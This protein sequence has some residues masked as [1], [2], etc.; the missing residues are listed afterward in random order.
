MS[1]NAPALTVRQRAVISLTSDSWEHAVTQA[2]SDA[3]RAGKPVKFESDQTGH[4]ALLFAIYEA[5]DH[6]RICEERRLETWLAQQSATIGRLVLCACDRSRPAVSL[7]KV[8]ELVIDQAGQLDSFSLR[9]YTVEDFSGQ[10]QGIL[11]RQMQQHSASL[12]F[13]D[14]PIDALANDDAIT[15]RPPIF[16]IGH[17]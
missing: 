12:A 6:A 3:Q 16:R 2:I 14:D 4:V 11:G 15:P 10:V 13:V 5:S 8:R 1:E 7:K 17:V 9:A